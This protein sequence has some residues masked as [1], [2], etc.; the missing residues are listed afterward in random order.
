MSLMAKVYA[1]TLTVSS[2]IQFTRGPDILT[3]L[4]VRQPA[5]GGSAGPPRHALGNVLIWQDESGSDPDVRKPCRQPVDRCGAWAGAAA[6]DGP[7][8]ST[9]KRPRVS[10]KYVAGVFRIYAED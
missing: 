10:A 4:T 6:A 1:H 3:P 8:V 9:P 2:V 5:D 7:G